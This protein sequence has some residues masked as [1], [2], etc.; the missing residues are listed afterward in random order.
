MKITTPLMLSTTIRE[1]R[2]KSKLTQAETAELVGIK[3]ATVS[4]FESKPESTKLGTLFKILASLE[5]E[6]RVVERGSTLG[7]VKGWD[8]EW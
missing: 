4:D 3:Q 7:E 6:L 1:Y 2:K 8:K 5:L